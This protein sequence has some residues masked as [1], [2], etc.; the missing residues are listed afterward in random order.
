MSPHDVAPHPHPWRAFAVIAVAIFLTIL[1]LFIVNVALPA[2]TVAF[3]RVPLGQLSWVLTGYAVVFA[4]GLVPAGKLGD[5]YG[6][7]RFFL[8]GLAIFLL[9][10]AMA[11]VSMSL[12]MLLVGRAVQAVGAAVVTPNSLGLVLPLFAP[13]RRPVV[14][15]AWG[16]LAG[17]GAAFGPPLGGLLA[18]VDWR[19]IFLINLPIGIAAM[20]LLRRTTPEIRDTTTVRF[21]DLVGTLSLAAGIGALT[22]GFSQSAPWNW[23]ARVI[24]SFVVAAVLITV[25]GVRSARH[26]SPVVELDVLREPALRLVLAATVVFWAGFAALLISSALFL[27]EVWDYTSLET[28]LGATPGPALSAVTAGLS[29]RLAD[30]IGAPRVGV[31]GSGLL[32]V[33]AIWLLVGPGSAPAYPTAFLPAQL[34]AGAGIGL[35][36]P[37]IMVI[38]VGH[39]PAAR[40]ATGIAV[41]SAF[42]QVGAALG[43][44]VWVAAVGAEPGPRAASYQAGWWLIAALAVAT[45]AIMALIHRIASDPEDPSGREGTLARDP[46]GRR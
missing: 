44:A 15:A 31:L 11:A 25:V 17:L 7:R 35:V 14:I 23:D 24:G 41:N 22:L 36:L 2:M 29:S 34:L 45:A 8:G 19:L 32:A 28:G 9:G 39:L 18:E 27:A 21:P 20:L 42:R 16:V 43:V 13:R 46:R 37:V 5:L 10:S 1:D 30:R 38:T 26:P 12:P 6:R 40:L 4:A 33:A 3:P